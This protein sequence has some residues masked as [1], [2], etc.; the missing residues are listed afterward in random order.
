[1]AG[2]GGEGPEGLKKSDSGGSSPV[3]CIQGGRKV[4]DNTKTP[5]RVALRQNDLPLFL[6]LELASRT[7]SWK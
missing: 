2:V 3:Q 5:R 6:G 4:V 7:F 1:M